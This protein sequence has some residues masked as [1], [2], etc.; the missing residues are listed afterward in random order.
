MFYYFTFRAA[1]CLPS[2][3]VGDSKTLA[4][5]PWSTTHEQLTEQERLDSG[6]TED[7]IRISVGT[8][9][10][11]PSASYSCSFHLENILDIIEDFSQSFDAS[12][13]IKTEGGQPEN[14]KETGSTDGAATLSG[15]T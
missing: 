11:A 12:R 9:S 15:A 14:A 5:H 6:V 1:S 8:G 13:D 3:S 7:M 10:F 4:I 2:T